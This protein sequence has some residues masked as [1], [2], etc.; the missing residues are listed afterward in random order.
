VVLAWP[1]AAPAQDAAQ[2]LDLVQELSTLRCLGV[3]WLVGGDGNR[4]AVV[5]ARYRRAADTQWRGAQNLFR[6]DP[7]GMRP[8]ACRPAG[9]AWFAG[10]VFDL[11]PGTPYELELTLHKSLV[12]GK[13]FHTKLFGIGHAVG[14]L[15]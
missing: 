11:A 9:S 3:R 7:A 2:A 1:P 15:R 8:E 10:S 5:S 14:V 13:S 12:T 4:N 6:V